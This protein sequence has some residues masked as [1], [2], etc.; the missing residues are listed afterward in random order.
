MA[1]NDSACELEPFDQ[2]GEYVSSEFNLFLADR[3]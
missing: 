1:E 3:R 2:V